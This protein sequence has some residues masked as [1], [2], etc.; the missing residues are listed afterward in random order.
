MLCLLPLP[1]V[2]LLCL[3]HLLIIYF[4]CQSTFKESFHP[5]AFQISVMCWGWHLSYRS[6]SFCLF[7]KFFAVGTFS[8]LMSSF[9]FTWCVL[10]AAGQICLLGYPST[11]WSLWNTLEFTTLL[12][13]CFCNI[14]ISEHDF[15]L[16]RILNWVTGFH[17][18]SVLKSS[19]PILYCLWGLFWFK[20]WI[21]L[22]FQ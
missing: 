11:H 19:F 15:L 21:W 22:Q 20:L 8:F 18:L 2:N 3:R 17:R 13:I 6:W 12:S 5:F 10:E 16:S 4:L 9:S 14:Y 1:M 7:Y